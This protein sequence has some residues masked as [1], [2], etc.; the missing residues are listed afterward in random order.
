[1]KTYTIYKATNSVNGKVY[2]G[3]TSNWPQRING[4]NY[5]RR[6][7]KIEHKA[8][9]KAIK[10]Y[11]WENFTWEAIYQSLD[12]IHTL[13]VMEPQFIEEYRSWVGYQDCNGYNTTKGGEGVSGYKRRADVVESHREKMKGRKCSPEHVK[14]RI[15]SFKKTM[16]GRGTRTGTKHTPESIEKMRQAQLGIPKSEEHKKAMRSRPQDTIQLTCP[17]C[18][19]TGPYKN[20][21]HWHMDRCKHNPNREILPKKT[22]TCSTCGHTATLSPNFYR[23]HMD[24]CKNDQ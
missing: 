19:K 5:D 6:Y 2:I 9:Y 7:G 20:M 17:H 23:Y 13:T 11:G 1:M 24:N 14:K 21:M 18:N 8:F 16:A 15:E 4:H 10:K 12:E 3:F 22:V